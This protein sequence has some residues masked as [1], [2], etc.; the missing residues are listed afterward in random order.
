MWNINKLDFDN[1]NA[2]RCSAQCM[3]ANKFIKITQPGVAHY[4]SNVVNSF[5]VA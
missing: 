3:M 1:A 5:N 2:Y 4:S